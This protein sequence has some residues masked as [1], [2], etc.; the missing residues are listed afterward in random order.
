MTGVG[1]IKRS[2]LDRIES[3]VRHEVYF[4]HLFPIRSQLRLQGMCSMC[5]GPPKRIVF[6]SVYYIS[7][8]IYYLEE[9]HLSSRI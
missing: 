5:T 4:L 3:K 7:Q 1:V 6:L 2:E 8:C 9:W